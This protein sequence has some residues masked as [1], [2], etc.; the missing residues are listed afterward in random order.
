MAHRI[1]VI[2]PYFGPLPNYFDLWLTT[3]AANADID[4]LIITDQDVESP[5]SNVTIAQSSL[6]A[7]SRKFQQLVDF[8]IS[9]DHP[10]KLCDFRPAYGQAFPEFTE[11]YSFWGHADVDVIWGRLRTFVTDEI[12]DAN[13][14]VFGGGHFSLYRNQDSVNNAFRLVSQ[15][16]P[17]SYREVFSSPSSFAF[18]EWGAAWNGMN[19]IMIE[20]GFRMYLE[21]MPYADIKVHP[22]VFRNNREGFGSPAERAHERAKRNIVYAYDR[23]QLRQYWL[24]S[25][26]VV[27]D[28]EEAYIHLQKRPI[29]RD[30]V[31]ESC[32]SFAI[33]PPD[34]FAPHPGTVEG[35]YLLREAK[36][37]GVY[38]QSLRIRR[39]NAVNKLRALKI[40]R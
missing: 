9:L 1:I 14:R 33:L 18:D 28:R 12:L 32:D 19:S 22:R 3:A 30:A 2:I 25:D 15:S 40:R 39:R 27:H 16:R 23:R 24:S 6:G 17:L 13:D 29:R 10:F 26:E 5:S 8:P 4:W 35:A 31:P 36:G 20:S 11:G 37:S 34:R 7:I 38:W 21:S